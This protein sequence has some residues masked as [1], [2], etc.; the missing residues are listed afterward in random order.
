MNIAPPIQQHILNVN[1]TIR[2]PRERVFAAFTTVEDLKKWF[3]P[4]QCHVTDGTMDFQ[5]GGAYR[6]AMET[7]QS[8]PATIS[9]IYREIVPN[10]RISFTWIWSDN[11][12]MDSWGDM[13]VT[14]QLTDVPEGTLV[15]ITHRGLL[16]PELEEGH[17]YGWEGCL[18]KME[19]LFS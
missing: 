3:G 10:E 19:T 13:D 17:R 16:S 18:D 7:A 2:A 15:S 14:V 1:R 9:G 5:V 11:P 8:G 12:I 6:L 4:D